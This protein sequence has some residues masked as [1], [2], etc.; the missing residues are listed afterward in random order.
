VDTI[1][2]YAAFMSCYRILK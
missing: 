1:I 2:D